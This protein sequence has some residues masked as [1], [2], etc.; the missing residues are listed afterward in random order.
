MCNARLASPEQ[1]ALSS[2]VGRA[3]QGRAEQGIVGQGRGGQG[4][5]YLSRWHSSYKNHASA[6]ELTNGF[7]TTKLLRLMWKDRGD[8]YNSVFADTMPQNP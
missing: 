1:C 7:E 8:C 3:R 6:F 4:R 5:T 2:P